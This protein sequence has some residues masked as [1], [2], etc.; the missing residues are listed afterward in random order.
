MTGQSLFFFLPAHAIHHGVDC[1][2][3]LGLFKIIRIFMNGPKCTNRKNEET[4]DLVLE[5]FR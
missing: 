1:K 5:M 4:H 3:K 2:N